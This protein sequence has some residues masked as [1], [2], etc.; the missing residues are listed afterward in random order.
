MTK[1]GALPATAPSLA[2]PV[3]MNIQALTRPG[4]WWPGRARTTTA[5]T[6][7]E[8]APSA[9]GSAAL[10]Q[11]ARLLYLGFEP[12]Q[13]C[14]HC[15]AVTIGS[16]GRLYPRPMGTGSQLGERRSQCVLDSIR[17]HYK[18]GLTSSSRV[19]FVLGRGM[20]QLR[21]RRAGRP[22]QLRRRCLVRLRKFLRITLSDHLRQQDRLRYVRGDDSD[23]QGFPR[24]AL[25]TIVVLPGGNPHRAPLHLHLQIDFGC[26]FWL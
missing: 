9:A 13:A 24:I 16:A 15:H 1:T 5:P 22:K 6:K 2:M 10:R 25:P 20:P 26:I 7:A 19:F 23:Y 17:L 21:R 8:A 12:R 11:P 14:I 3:G 18:A 4:P